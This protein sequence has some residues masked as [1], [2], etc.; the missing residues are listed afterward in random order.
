MVRHVPAKFF[1]LWIGCVSI[2]DYR[3]TGHDLVPLGSEV[4]LS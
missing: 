1:F 4:T 2:H 3:E